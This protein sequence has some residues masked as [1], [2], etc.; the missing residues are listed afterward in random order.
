[1]S[2]SELAT[3]TSAD[4]VSAADI[5]QLTDNV[6]DTRLGMIPIG[7]I[8]PWHKSFANTPALPGQFAEMNGQTVS[9]SDSPYN[10]QTLPNWNIGI[11][12]KGGSTS[13][14]ETNEIASGTGFTTGTVV[15][16]IRIK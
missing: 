16:V 7:G 6:T 2:Y 4:L 1:M 8:I 13:G 5:N 3:R 10:G 9:D 11:I 12:P 15:W 14:T